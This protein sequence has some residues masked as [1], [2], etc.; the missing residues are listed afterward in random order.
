MLLLVFMLMF[1]VAVLFIINNDE[2]EDE[3]DR[4]VVPCN[5]VK[6]PDPRFTKASSK[7]PLAATRTIVTGSPEG[8][9]RVNQI[10]GVNHVELNIG[11]KQIT[12]RYIGELSGR[13]SK[14][15]R[16]LAHTHS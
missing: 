2:E 9:I 16:S 10:I 5:P 8:P 3:D 15:E 13:M 7:V 6:L 1:P 14:G 12:M 11:V 4:M